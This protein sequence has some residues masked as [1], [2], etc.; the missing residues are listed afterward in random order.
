M[1]SRLTDSSAARVIHISRSTLRG[2]IKRGSLPVD[3]EGL[4][5]TADLQQLGYT[6]DPD[7]LAREQ[8]GQAR[9]TAQTSATAGTPQTDILPQA[10]DL[11]GQLR[12]EIRGE[13]D[14]AHARQMRL[15]RLLERLSRY[16]A[17]AGLPGGAA[18]LS[19]PQPPQIRQPIMSLLRQHPQGLA[20]KDIE[21]TLHSPKNLRNTLQGMHRAGLLVRR[22]TGVYAVAPEHQSPEA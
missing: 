10:L 2:V 12:D 20:R 5:D 21:T 9:G 13:L 16:I 17:K 18:A 4:V 8:A 19:A 3:P 11:F 15:L 22:Q 7:A 14:A 6:V 1:S